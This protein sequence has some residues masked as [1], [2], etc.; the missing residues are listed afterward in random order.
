[1]AGA[2]PKESRRPRAANHAPRGRLCRGLTMVELL[3]TITILAITAALLLPSLG[4]ARESARRTACLNN[5]SQIGKSIMSYDSSQNYLPGWRMAL[6]GFTELSGQCVSWSVA[7]LPFLGEREIF[8]G[9]ESYANAP[10]GLAEVQSKRLPRY[11]CPTVLTRVSPNA[12]L[13]YVGN[14]GTGAETLNGSQQWRGDGVF[15]DMVGSA[16]S[17][18]PMTTS[19]A[20]IADRD[21]ASSTMLLTE[22]GGIHAPLQASWAHAPGPAA[23][24]ANAVLTTHAVLHPPTA[25]LVSGRPPIG[26]R[27]VNPTLETTISANADWPFRFPSSMHDGGAA[28][29][30]CDGRTQFM[31]E[32][33]APWVYCQTLTS[34]RRTES[35]RA[36]A[37]EVYPSGASWTR[38]V[39][40]ERDL[41]P[42][43]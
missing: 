4:A 41:T 7:I 13:T 16:G 24:N 19:V 30:F 17:Y 21:G 38:Y 22:R 37:W 20:R 43:Q 33:V 15:F 32:Q 18:D 9:Y 31:S 40:D 28:V 5:L 3:V 26:R 1:M 35:P 39:F 6:P 8:D 2:H 27:I 14:A 25:A 12:P 36:A 42:K 10:A 11:V 34:D 23:A 29:A